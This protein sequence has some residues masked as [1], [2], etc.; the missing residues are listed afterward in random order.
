MK[1]FFLSFFSIALKK[2]IFF[3]T[4]KIKIEVDYSENLDQLILERGFS[5]TD[6][7]DFNKCEP[8]LINK[9]GKK[10]VIVKI[11]KL[12]NY[13]DYEKA[14]KKIE[15]S[16]YAPSTMYELLAFDQKMPDFQR[17]NPVAAFGHVLRKNGDN[18]PRL[19]PCLWGDNSSRSL[20]AKESNPCLLWGNGILC[21]GVKK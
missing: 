14:V 5:K 11:F 18:G 6:G 20:I 7:I 16:G 8:T 17:K 13:Y 15:R 12:R 19:I 2:L 3:I 21:L 10:V 9:T 4:A 1:K